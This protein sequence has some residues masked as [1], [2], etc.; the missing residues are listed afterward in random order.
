ME[1]PDIP[2]SSVMA[3]L[4]EKGFNQDLHSHFTFVA[5]SNDDREVDLDV[6]S[7]TVNLG[8]LLEDWTVVGARELAEELIVWLGANPNF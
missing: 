1:Y 8:L 6:E 3:F 5:D 2:V 4:N 7:Q